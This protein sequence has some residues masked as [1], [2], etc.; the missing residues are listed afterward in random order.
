LFIFLFY[1]SEKETGDRLSLKNRIYQ[2]PRNNNGC[3]RK[4][5]CRFIEFISSGKSYNMRSGVNIQEI[6]AI[7]MIAAQ[8][9]G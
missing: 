9:I 4:L 3:G 5:D 7:T 2:L 8:R 6:G 1:K